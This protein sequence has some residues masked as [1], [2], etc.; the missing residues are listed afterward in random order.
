[1][2]LFNIYCW[3]AGIILVLIP[4]CII[5]KAWRLLIVPT[6]AIILLT[7]PMS[8]YSYDN[9]SRAVDFRKCVNNEKEY[10][11]LLKRQEIPY[12]IKGNKVRVLFWSTEF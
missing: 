11:D 4:L 8:L 1:M 5:F 10:I 12:T 9:I 3:I 7:I 6:V 2:S